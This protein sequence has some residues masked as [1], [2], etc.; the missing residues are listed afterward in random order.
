MFNVVTRQTDSCRFLEAGTDCL[1]CERLLGTHN[2]AGSIFFLQEQIPS[3]VSLLLC[4]PEN[5]TAIALLVLIQS[6]TDDAWY[7]PSDRQS[8]GR[9]Q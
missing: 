2:L 4:F 9:H 5:F 8:N 7:A 3:S 6:E 1:C